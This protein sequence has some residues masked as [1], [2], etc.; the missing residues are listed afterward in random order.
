MRKIYLFWFQKSCH[1]ITFMSA[2][3]S[4]PFIV[5]FMAYFLG[6]QIACRLAFRR[7][8]HLSDFLESC[9]KARRSRTIM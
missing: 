4:P 6:V 9:E 5:N 1:F 7:P 3:G 8:E 2:I